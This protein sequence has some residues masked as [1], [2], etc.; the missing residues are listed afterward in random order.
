MGVERNDV[1]ADTAHMTTDK[2]P[3]TDPTATVIGDVLTITAGF[4]DIREQLDKTFQSGSKVIDL[5]YS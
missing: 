2:Q 4:Q 3:F 5:T 1:V